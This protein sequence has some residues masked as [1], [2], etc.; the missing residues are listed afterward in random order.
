MNF[1]IKD[2]DS[3][4]DT[5]SLQD[6]VDSLEDDFELVLPGWKKLERRLLRV[7]QYL[8][9]T[10]EMGCMEAIFSLDMF[11]YAINPDMSRRDRTDNFMRGIG[12]MSLYIARRPDLPEDIRNRAANVNFAV[13][14]MVER[15][16]RLT[17]TTFERMKR[18]DKLTRLKAN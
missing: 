6:D 13:G 18:E 2:V 16:A 7:R 1:K 12:W 3:L 9:D 10:D 8:D 5:D 17:P 15:M 11:L 4:E 14:D